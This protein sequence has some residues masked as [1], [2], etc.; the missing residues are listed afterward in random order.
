MS[1]PGL[2]VDFFF[3]GLVLLDLVGVL[4][5]FWGLLLFSDILWNFKLN[6]T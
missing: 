6:I 5:F 3:G 2:E 4:C 1:A